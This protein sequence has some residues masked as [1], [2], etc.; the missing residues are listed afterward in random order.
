MSEVA[1]ERPLLCAI[2]DAQ[3]LDHA[4][5][6]AIG[7]VARQATGGT[8]CRVGGNAWADRRIREAA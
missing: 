4:S 8:S 2:D 5:A 6:A 3:W 1:E 7:F